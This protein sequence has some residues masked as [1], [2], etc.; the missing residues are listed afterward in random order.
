ME[1]NLAVLGVGAIGSCIGVDLTMAGYNV[2]L[3]DQWPAHV[4]AMKAK[5]LRMIMP[6]PEE[7]L[8]TPVRALHLCEVSALQP[9]LDIVF[10]SSKSYD[11]C[12]M[13]QF[14]KPYLKSEGVVVSIQNSLND[15]WLAPIIGKDRDLACVVELSAAIFEPGRVKRKISHAHT[16]FILGELDGKITPRLLEVTQILKNVAGIV[17]TTPNIMGNKWTKIVFN[18]M[19]GLDAI[20]GVPTKELVENHPDILE[21]MIKVGQESIKVPL[22]LGYTLD[23][24]FGMTSSDFMNSTDEV[25]KTMFRKFFSVV[26][27]SRPSHALQDIVKGRRTEL[28]YMNGL[29]VE[30]GRET[31]VSTPLNETVLS[32]V[33]Q[34]EQGKLKPGLSNFEI[35]KKQI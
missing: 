13:A 6:P 29:I 4:E 15:E 14:V 27:E 33:T 11:T 3:I 12:W 32:L 25:L 5:G 34:I 19:S 21:I 7:E 26:R 24:I 30:K 20:A 10:L 28:H 18:S 22:A 35:F 16:M 31:K 8:H 1:K 2:L 23:P 17:E 9:Q